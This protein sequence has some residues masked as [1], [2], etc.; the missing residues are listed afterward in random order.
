[1]KRLLHALLPLL[2]LN[3]SVK[4]Q[5]LVPNPSL[6]DMANCPLSGSEIPFPSASAI[7]VSDWYR[8]S[9]ATS[10]YFNSCHVD[11]GLGSIAG[12]PSNFAGYQVPKEGEGYAGGYCY[13]NPTGEELDYREYIQTQLNAPLISGRSYFVSYYTSLADG[14]TDFAGL[15]AI[16]QMGA[17]FSLDP[18]ERVG[19][20]NALTDLIPQ[21]AS[22]VGV[23]MDDTLNW[24]NV[25]GTFTA[26]GGE[27]WMIIGNFTPLDELNYESVGPDIDYSIGYYYFDEFCVLDMTVS[28]ISYKTDTTFCPG[29]E[30][31]LSGQNSYTH[32]NWDNGATTQLRT[33]TE[34][35]I[36]W[37]TSINASTCTSHIDTI[38]VVVAIEPLEI[39]L[40]ND[41][42]VCKNTPV[43]LNA[44]YEG[45]TDY[46]WNTGEQT[47]SILAA[48]P[49]IYYVTA[50]S[51]CYLGTDTIV[52]SAAS[53]PN[54]ELPADAILCTG[55][56]L[57]LGVAMGNLQYLWN[58]GENVCCINVSE[59]GN[60]ILTATN[61]C[62][63]SDSDA[64]TVG[65]SECDYCILA[66]TAFTPNGDGLNDQFRVAVRCKMKN[67][68]L[69]IFSRW[70][71]MVF[72]TTNINDGWDGYINGSP[73]NMGVYF[74]YI[75]GEPAIETIGEIKEKGDI[76]LIR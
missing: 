58:T 70:G 75:E 36:Y 59:P 60:Y 16:D 39:N 30:M 71:Q 28:S 56:E 27:E 48:Y 51:D 76:T 14:M 38:N 13:N 25:S 19:E 34:A 44:F 54:V 32:Y 11:L 18:E 12:T 68:S 69:K 55:T 31:A 65:Y 24:M 4:A 10:D 37:V 35:G 67:Y 6:E 72:A 20:F 62:G 22:P 33:I 61:I 3:I 15:T 41:T 5:N 53:I 43:N 66:P 63:E 9:G 52:I 46:R 45:Y 1:M 40:G 26:A 21:V 7:S 29:T 23:M 57:S 49:G 8:P 17:Y 2:F 47:S 74:Y 42:V 73:A 64:I 50:S